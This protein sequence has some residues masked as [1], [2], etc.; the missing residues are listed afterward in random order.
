MFAIEQTISDLRHDQ[1]TALDRAKM[2][3]MNLDNFHAPTEEIAKWGKQRDYY[4][5][6]ADALEAQIQEDL[7]MN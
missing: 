4:L 1:Q 2:H 5:C 7:R 3:Q 6:K